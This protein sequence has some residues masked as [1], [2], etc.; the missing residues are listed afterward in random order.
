MRLWACE[1][2]S[3]WVDK[4]MSSWVC[5]LMSCCVSKSLSWCIWKLL[6]FHEYISQCVDLS[7]TSYMKKYLSC[8]GTTKITN[9]YQFIERLKV[10]TVLILKF[11][12]ETLRKVKTG[13]QTMTDGSKKKPLPDGCKAK[14]ALNYTSSSNGWLCLLQFYPITKATNVGS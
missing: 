10:K 4:F 9:N 2:M 14:L 6:V 3:W 1:L 7:Y 8:I 13:G 12:L 5:K 11:A